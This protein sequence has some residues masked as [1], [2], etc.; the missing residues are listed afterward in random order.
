MSMDSTIQVRIDS[1]VKA[2]VEELYR[3]LGTS[4]AEAVRIFAQQS[5]LMG[6]IDR[7]LS[8]SEADIIAGRIFTQQEADAHME[9]KFR[10]E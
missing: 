10:Y 5:L 7:K 9:A 2:N 8:A 6:D 4:F 3:N 1:Q